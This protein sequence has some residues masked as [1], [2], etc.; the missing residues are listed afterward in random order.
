MS[1]LSTTSCCGN[2][3]KCDNGMNPILMIVLLLCLCG[4]DNGLFGFGG[5]SSCGCGGGLDGILPIILLLCLC[6]GGSLF[7]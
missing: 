7:C 2:N 6:G 5:N 3:N 4:G 1:D